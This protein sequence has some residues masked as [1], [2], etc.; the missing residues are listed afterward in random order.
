MKNVL[1]VDDVAF[2]RKILTDIFTNNDFNVVGEAGDGET[3][4]EQYI[5]LKPDF[6]TMD[7]TMP[8]IDGISAV[9]NIIKYDN[10]A[11]IIICSVLAQQTKVVE[12]IRAG[13]KDFV[14]K[15]IEADK[16][17]KAANRLFKTENS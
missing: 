5:K 17:I 3:A 9:R 13:A 11:K 2:M 10:D 1:I 6:V 14:A 12:A 7:I 15:P 16:L 8:S 4:L